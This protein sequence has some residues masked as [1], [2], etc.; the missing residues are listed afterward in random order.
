LIAEPTMTLQF[1]EEDLLRELGAATVGKGGLMI[2]S[3][4]YRWRQA[5]P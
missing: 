4:K 5:E 3:A 1:S 2:A